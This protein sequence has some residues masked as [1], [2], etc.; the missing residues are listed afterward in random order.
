MTGSLDF[1]LRV[2]NQDDYDQLHEMC[3]TDTLSVPAFVVEFNHLPVQG[4]PGK[5]DRP[6]VDKPVGV[7]DET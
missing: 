1:I 2:S 6:V 4:L 7:L 3:S 5:T